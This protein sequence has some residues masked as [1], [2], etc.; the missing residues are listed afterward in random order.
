MTLDQL[1]TFLAVLEHGGFSHAAK[2][3]GIGQSTISF[4]IRALEKS[5]GVRLLDRGKSRV[6]ATPA[7]REL[8]RYATRMI[9]LESE[10]LARL[11][12]E[13]S[14]ESG[15]VQIAAS[16]I[17]AEYLLPPLLARFHRAHPRVAIQVEV[18]DSRR[19]VQAL[20]AEECDFAV[21]GARSR[22]PRLRYS[23]FASDEIVLVGPARGPLGKTRR[24][25]RAQ[26][27][28]H[29]LVLREE[30][31]GTR[32]AI[33]AVLGR[34]RAAHAAAGARTPLL[35]GSSEAVRRCVLEGLGLGFIS[36]Y[37]VA[38]DLA[39]G[40]LQ[41]ISLP[42]LPVRR[43]FFIARLAGVTL[44]ASVRALL[45]VMGRKNR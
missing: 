40:R 24:L 7:G 41:N 4:H 23:V 45:E 33:D 13:E 1:R 30:G 42:G 26:L 2:A 15:R 8:R 16:T 44:P 6:R 25:S 18:S 9:A 20:L 10:A 3:R 17:P 28:T 39:A 36:R 32:D 38:E 19:A 27:A 5:L 11:R 35:V 31:S 14:G 21:V 12:E 43:Q 22:E 34:S 29:T 37:A